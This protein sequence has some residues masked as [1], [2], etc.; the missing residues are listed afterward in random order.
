MSYDSWKATRLADW[1]DDP[2]D[3]DYPDEEETPMTYAELFHAV[4]NALA[5]N[6]VFTVKVETFRHGSGD[7]VTKWEIYV[8]AEE[9]KSKFYDGDT[10]DEAFQ[11]FGADYLAPPHDPPTIETTSLSVNP[12]EI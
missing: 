8:Q 12:Q 7:V 1:R 5:T 3:D 11:K 4:E 10:A 9:T 2:A 6:R